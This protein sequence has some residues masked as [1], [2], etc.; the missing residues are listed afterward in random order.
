MDLVSAEAIDI[1]RLVRLFGGTNAPIETRGRSF[2]IAIVV[3]QRMLCG[4]P[5]FALVEVLYLT[6]RHEERLQQRDLSILVEIR[7]RIRQ[8]FREEFSET[9]V[10]LLEAA[11]GSRNDYTVRRGE[12]IN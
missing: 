5:P 12:L 1:C 9:C 8:R 2:A 4:K 3:Q 7:R 6:R 10:I 11:F